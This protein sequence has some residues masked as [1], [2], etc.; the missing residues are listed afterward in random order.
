VATYT[1]P[2]RDIR[3]VLHDLLGV[4]QLSALEPFATA[5]PDIVDAVLEQAAELCEEV[6]LPLNR[7]GD[8]QGCT[9]E[10]GVV[11]TPAGLREAYRAF[12][13]GGWTSLAADAACGG[14]GLPQ[15]LNFVLFEMIC[16][17]NMAFGTYLA[18]SEAA[19]LLL[20]THGSQ[21][22]KRTYLPP[23]IDGR[24]SATM[25]LTEPQCGTDLGLV[26][27]RAAPR[28]DGSYSLTGTKTFVTAG[29]HDLTGN[30]LHNVLARLPGAPPGSKGLSLFLVP[31]FLTA[32]DGRPGPRNRVTCGG[33]EHKMG[34]HA[35]ATCVMNFDDA[36]GY[37]ISEPHGGLRCMF[38]MMNFARLAVGMQGLGLAET[39]YQSAVAYARERLQ[40]RAHA[41]VRRADAPADPIIVH[42]DVRRMLLT[43]RAYTEGARALAC[44]TALHMDLARHH[45]EADM[46]QQAEDLV[47]LMT[48]MVKAFFTDIGFEAANLGLQV[49]GGHG[50]IREHGMEQLVRDA[51]VGQIYEGTNGVQALDLV[52][53]KLGQHYGRL[54]RRMFHPIDRFIADHD[55]DPVLQEFVAPLGKAFN[56]L[57]R[58]TAWIAEQGVR[59]PVEPAA[60]ATEY[61]RLFGLVAVGFMWAR[62]AEVAHA[63][64]ADGASGTSF[65][66]AKIATARFFM[67]RILPQT[68][69]LFA[70]MMSGSR[71]IMN[72]PEECF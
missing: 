64:H 49:Y 42:P 63:A 28:D 38:T 34:L 45:P 24:W 31:K 69:S 22:I 50:Y 68:S 2:L 5:T 58:A 23:L 32:A 33:I 20:A 72:L 40:G 52:G 59:D 7:S 16:S 36:T 65:Y 11:R 70:A 9:F 56:R 25:C 39:A 51:R 47:Q 4:G 26:R 10:N 43:I 53:R 66:A 18:L 48:P 62:T 8:E 3:F 37:L 57:Q 21:E 60:A 19:A 6:L 71:P 14:Q 44:W 29:E 27:T 54:L 67:L 35:S 17:T 61:L 15:L 13:E 41:G 30:I 46:R 12:A 1:A 55:D